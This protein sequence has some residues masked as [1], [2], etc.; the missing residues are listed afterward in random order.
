MEEYKKPALKGLQKLKQIETDL[1]QEKRYFS[2]TR[3]LV[4]KKLC[5]NPDA[6]HNFAKS[7]CDKTYLLCKKDKSI[8]NEMKSLV[9]E[10]MQ[11]MDKIIAN[12][13]LSRKK[14]E[15]IYDKLIAYQNHTRSGHFGIQIRTINNNNLFLIELGIK[16]FLVDDERSGYEIGRNYSERYNARYGTGLI[17]ESLPYV[18]DIVGFWTGYLNS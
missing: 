10:S 4:L 8:T 6:R 2:I 9:E 16:C 15:T 18:K 1:Q 7:L 11:Q 5:K 13:K 14:L 3:L 17:P 12:N